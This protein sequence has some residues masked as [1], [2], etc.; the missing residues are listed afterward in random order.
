VV[1]VEIDLDKLTDADLR[2]VKSVKVRYNHKTDVTTTEIERFDP[3][4][5]IDQAIALLQLQQRMTD[6]TENSPLPAELSK[7]LESAA[8]NRQKFLER[9]PPSRVRQIIEQEAPRQ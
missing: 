2:T 6:S 8:R 4:R 3:S 1:R 7:I 9:L 5:G